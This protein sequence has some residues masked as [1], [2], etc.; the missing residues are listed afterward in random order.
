MIVNC[1]LMV[2]N[3]S[4]IVGTVRMCL[5]SQN[6]GILVADPTIP[7]EEVFHITKEQVT[8]LQTSMDQL[9]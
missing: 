8:S 7:T 4:G 3:P 2:E 9:L 6:G 5:V 1:E